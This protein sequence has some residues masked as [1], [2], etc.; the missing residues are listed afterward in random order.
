MAIRQYLARQLS[1]PTGIIG[2]YILGPLWNRRNSALNDVTLAHLDLQA[3]DRVLD[4]GFGGGYLIEQIISRVKSGLV[5]GVDVSAAMVENAQARWNEAIRAGRMDIQCASA[6]AL[7]FPDHAFTKVC[8]V[9]SIFYWDHPQ[10]GIAEIYRTLREN[11]QVVLTFTCQ[12]SLEKKW[13]AP[14][15]VRPYQDEDI[16]AM[17]VAA[18]FQRV[19]AE[20][21]RDQHREFICV[22]GYK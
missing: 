19:K 18:G 15:S 17:L 16:P 21:Y 11:G 5:A 12:R 14:Y 10:Q 9:N 22:I 13:F 20:P 7:P 3:D 8:S 6:E 2:K 1:H 4:I